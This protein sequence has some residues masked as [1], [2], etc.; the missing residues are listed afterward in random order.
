M[1][2]TKIQS[3]GI[4]DGTIVNADINASAGLVLTKLA[5]TGTLTVDNIQF[6][7]TAVASANANNLD[8]YEEG[9]WTPTDGSGASLSLIITNATYTKIGREVT[10]YLN[11]QYPSTANANNSQI[12]GLP[13]VP[14]NTAGGSDMAFGGF[15]TITNYDANYTIYIEAGNTIL[16]IYTRSIGRI[17]NATISGKIF[18]FV[19]KYYV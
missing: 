6:P 9:T 18:E 10:C 3:L 17:T 5:S 14:A 12:N 1:P 16:R 2:L 15:V 13:F 4:T 7:A 19:L 8:D 11:L